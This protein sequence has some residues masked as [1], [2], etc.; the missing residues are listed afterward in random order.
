MIGK[1]CFKTSSLAKVSAKEM[2][3][4]SRV[5]VAATHYIIWVGNVNWPPLPSR[6]QYYSSL[7]ARYEVHVQR[8]ENG[9]AVYTRRRHSIEKMFPTFENLR[10][11][12]S[13]HYATS[14]GR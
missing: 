9:P 2:Q 13:L 8:S 12:I 1:M 6:L 4:A 5:A 14:G 10:G 7:N 3:H 11:R